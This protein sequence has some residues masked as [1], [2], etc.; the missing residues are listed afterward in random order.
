MNEQEERE[1]KERPVQV[2]ITETAAGGNR[3]LKPQETVRRKDRCYVPVPSYCPPLAEG[4]SPGDI[5]SLLC[6][7]HMCRLRMLPG[8]Q[9]KLCNREVETLLLRGATKYKMPSSVRV[10]DKLNYF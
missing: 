3:D 4:Y 8:L 1:W 2:C 5:N 6:W 7:A 9:R 10:S